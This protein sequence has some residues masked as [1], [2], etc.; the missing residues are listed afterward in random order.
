M[1]GPASTIETVPAWDPPTRAC[2]WALVALVV[3]AWVSREYGD[4]ALTW[5]KLN[6]YAILILVAFRLLWGVAGPPAARLTRL[7]SGPRHIARQMRAAFRG[8][9]ADWLGHT[10][11]GGWM[12]A[13]LLALLAAQGVS[14]LFTADS[15]GVFGGPFAHTDFLSEPSRLQL[16]LSWLHHQGFDALM[17]LIVLH[18]GVALYHQFVRRDGLVTAMIT[19]RKVLR[20]FE[21]ATLA[22]APSGM[23]W[24]RAA[25]CFAAAAAI[26]VGGLVAAGAPLP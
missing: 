2:K 11:L 3:L 20:A 21:D 5:H 24:T 19:G 22:A 13:V 16:T 17:V 12:A 26:V 8:P 15:N 9:R 14:G 18:V 4:V 10:P 6:G 25:A 1:R 7:L 23:V